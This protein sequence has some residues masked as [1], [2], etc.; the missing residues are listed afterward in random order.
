MSNVLSLVPKAP[1]PARP[2]YS[3]PKELSGHARK[4]WNEHAPI[5]EERGTLN[6]ETR[7]L[8]AAYCGALAMIAEIDRALHKA[9]LIIKG[10]SGIPRPHPLVGARSRASQNALQ[11]A[12]RLGLGQAS[13]SP[14][15][16]GGTGHADPYSDL[17]I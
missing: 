15:S 14:T 7:P 2:K 11:L 13:A 17:G 10:P 4:L 9:K 3:G 8:L 6:R 12:K 16:K 1:K 5:L